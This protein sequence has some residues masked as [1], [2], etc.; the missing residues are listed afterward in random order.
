MLQRFIYRSNAKDEHSFGIDGRRRPSRLRFCRFEWSR[1]ED[2]HHA[3]HSKGD[4]SGRSRNTR[5]VILAA[6]LIW[7]G[8]G[9]GGAAAQPSLGWAQDVPPTNWHKRVLGPHDDAHP[10]AKYEEEQMIQAPS[11]IRRVATRDASRI[12]DLLN[13]TVGRI[14]PDA[15]ALNHGIRVTR[16]GPGEYTVETAADVAC[17]YT[18]DEDRV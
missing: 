8:F 10:S 2:S 3:A 7:G 17:G 16:T 6:S 12:D 5:H 18:I 9:S 13:S 1:P 15:L 11:T 14:I 4:K